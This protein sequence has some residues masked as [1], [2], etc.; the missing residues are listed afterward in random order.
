MGMNNIFLDTNVVI[1]IIEQRERFC[2]IKTKLFD[3]G[4]MMEIKLFMS[5]NSFADVYYI[6]RK[7]TSKTTI[8]EKLKNITILDSTVMSCT[9]AQLNTDKHDDIEDIMQIACCNENKINTFITAD[10]E[11]IEK[12]GHLFI[13]KTKI[14]LIQ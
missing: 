6:L 2:K 8:D 11:L 12:Y 10:P 4:E 13:H 1:D 5:A 14:E 9:F 7:I 3:A